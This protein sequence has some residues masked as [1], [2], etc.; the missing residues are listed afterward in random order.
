[1][2]KEE[3]L[4]IENE[5]YLSTGVQIGAKYK[6]KY[7]ED[8]IY[9]IRP[10]GL[11]VLNIQKIDSRIR[12]ATTMLAQ[13]EPSEILA[14][15]RRDNCWSSLSKFG[16]ITEIKTVAGR[17]LPGTMTNPMYKERFYEP[18]IL[19]VCDPWSDKNA[20][21]D[22]VKIGIP[23][24]SLC[25]TNNVTNN[26]DLVLPCNNK[27]RKSVAMIFYLLAREYLKLRK[28][29]NSNEEFNYKIEDFDEA[30]KTEEVPVEATEAQVAQE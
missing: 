15:T 5:K 1:M 22:A 11:A 17:Y 3:Q 4:L 6:T 21:D 14:T 19:L 30:A 9:K 18:K 26:I 2:S 24:I 23:V 13:F 7:M 25:D 27:S 8:F 20:V 16:K 28:K 12:R 29:I 10:D